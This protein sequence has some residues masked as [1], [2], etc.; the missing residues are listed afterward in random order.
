MEE[1]QQSPFCYRAKRE[2][3]NQ[4]WIIN[5]LVYI[6]HEGVKNQQKHSAKPTTIYLYLTNK[7]N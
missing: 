4:V 3:N 1:I 5:A 2:G 7:S 6:C